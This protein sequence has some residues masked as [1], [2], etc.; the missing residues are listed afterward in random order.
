MAGSPQ[1]APADKA[2]AATGTDHNQG[3]LDHI[4]AYLDK[5]SIF[6]KDN[7]LTSAL[8]G[9]VPKDADAAAKKRYGGKSGG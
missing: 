9:A 8:S 6:S 7:A 5:H 4:K 3:L 1:Q 2:A